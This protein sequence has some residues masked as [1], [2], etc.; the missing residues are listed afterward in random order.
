MKKILF[1]IAVS[2]LAFT[3]CSKKGDPG[4]TG[5]AGNANVHSYSFTIAPGDWQHQ[6]TAGNDY[7][8]FVDLPVTAITASM[9]TSG[10]VLINWD[11]SGTVTT[12]PV[13]IPSGTNI[14]FYQP[15][16]KLGSARVEI[17]RQDNQAFTANSNF[18][19]RVVVIN[20][21]ARL[22]H[23]EVNWSSPSAVNKALGVF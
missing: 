9:I 22:A 14:Y 20:E 13:T 23:P 16:F 12:L 2:S 19:F 21:S 7:E 1:F 6:G 4:A 15:T 5:P 17:Y 11:L 3:S 10:Q 8:L 18:S